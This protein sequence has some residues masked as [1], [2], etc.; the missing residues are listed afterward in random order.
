M[1]DTPVFIVHIEED[2]YLTVGEVWPDK[3]G[4]KDPTAEDV[5]E[6]MEQAGRKQRVLRDWCLLQDPDV[7]VSGP[8]LD[9]TS[10]TVKVWK[11]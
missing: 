3:D 9:G 6:A 11:P 2:I 4:P 8:G 10:A 1:S 5:A 7:W